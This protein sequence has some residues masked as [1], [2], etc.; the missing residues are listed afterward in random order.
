M[1][2]I[3]VILSDFLLVQLYDFGAQIF[4]GDSLSD[5]IT[6]VEEITLDNNCKILYCFSIDCDVKP[7]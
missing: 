7:I 1:S 6:K 3:E 4:L 2:N 5:G